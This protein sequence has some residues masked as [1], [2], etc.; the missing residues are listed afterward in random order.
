MLFV[1]ATSVYALTHIAGRPHALGGVLALF[2]V[3]NTV[4][5][6]F[7]G[8]TYLTGTVMAGTF[9]VIALGVWNFGSASSQG[10]QLFDSPSQT[11]GAMVGVILDQ[12]VMTNPIRCD[13]RRWHLGC[14]PPPRTWPSAT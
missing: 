3:L 5:P 1:I 9:A 14:S 7:V 10:R 6:A 8:N 13:S 2:T 11:T 12:L 4:A